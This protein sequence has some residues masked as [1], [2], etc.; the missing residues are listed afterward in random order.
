MISPSQSSPANSSQMLSKALTVEGVTKDGIDFARIGGILGLASGIL[1][2]IVGQILIATGMLGVIG[3][4]FG[5]VSTGA[6]G[7][8][9]GGVLG[10]GFGGAVGTAVFV[11]GWDLRWPS[12]SIHIMHVTDRNAGPVA[13]SVMPAASWRAMRA[14]SGLMPRATGR[15]WL[16][17]AESFLFEAPAAQR[18]QATRNYLV[19]A[20]QV[21]ALSWAAVLAQRTWLTGGG[22]TAGQSNV[23]DDSR[24]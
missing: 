9:A 2:L 8:V 24:G 22:Q 6:F 17:E 14:A 19:I 10:V 12:I 21:I 16:A 23:S 13:T 18:L 11:R 1:G 3:G 15:R 5:M 4:V 20:P 7:I